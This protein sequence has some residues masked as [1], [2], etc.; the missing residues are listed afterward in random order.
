MALTFPEATVISPYSEATGALENIFAQAKKREKEAQAEARE[1][2]L[3]KREQILFD[4]GQDDRISAQAEK[5]YTQ[6]RTRLADARADTEHNRGEFSRLQGLTADEA[7]KRIFG[8]TRTQPDLLP[9]PSGKSEVDLIR[10]SMAKRYRDSGISG[11]EIS[12]NMKMLDQILARQSAGALIS[13]KAGNYDDLPI[14]NP[15]MDNSRPMYPSEK[16]FLDIL[17]GKPTPKRET[18]IF[19]DGRGQPWMQQFEDGVPAGPPTRVGDPK[20]DS[21]KKAKE[22]L[23][24]RPAPVSDGAYVPYIDENGKKEWRYERRNREG[25]SPGTTIV[26]PDGSTS[27]ASA[28]IVQEMTMQDGSTG[29]FIIDPTGNNPL[30]FLGKG[31][32][33]FQAQFDPDGRQVHFFNPHT[34]QSFSRKLPGHYKIGGSGSILDDGTQIPPLHGAANVPENTDRVDDKGNLI[35]ENETLPEPNDLNNTLRKF[36]EFKDSS[37]PIPEE[38]GDEWYQERAKLVGNIAAS[39]AA[40]AWQSST[41]S[42]KLASILETGPTVNDAV[43]RLMEFQDKGIFDYTD[44]KGL[45]VLQGLDSATV[46]RAMSESQTG[47]RG[48]ASD[49][50]PRYQKLLDSFEGDVFEKLWGA[51]SQLALGVNTEQQTEYKRIMFTRI[52]DLSQS[53]AKSRIRAAAKKAVAEIQKE[54]HGLASVTGYEDREEELNEI[55]EE[56]MRQRLMDTYFPLPPSSVQQPVDDR[57]FQDQGIV[58]FPTLHIEGE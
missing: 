6:T 24:Q 22:H 4:Q 7:T 49:I 35:Y 16:K 2:E 42:Q 41:D 53:K 15:H 27:L 37:P 47:S 19:D 58:D 43:G 33:G 13:A 23:A 36:R 25:F 5:D 32:S 57:I 3:W 31:E 48:R 45:T 30:T 28:P 17:S 21:G 40:E 11:E 26:N 44:K 52:L 34:Q 8:A 54:N 56:A 50:L 14:S 55:L 38:R 9:G 39:S 51:V 46:A 29:Y 10:E 1:D 20:D 12:K 18:K